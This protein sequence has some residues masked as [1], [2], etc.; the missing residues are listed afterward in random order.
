MKNSRH[1]EVTFDNGITEIFYTLSDAKSQ[2]KSNHFNAKVKTIESVN[3][4]SEGDY[5]ST[6]L[7]IS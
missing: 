2:I 7:K 3:V 6:F 5:K 1:Y 4:T